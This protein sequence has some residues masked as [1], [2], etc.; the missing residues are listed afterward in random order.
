MARSH[1]AE[2]GGKTHGPFV[3][4]YRDLR[5]NQ[6][7]PEVEDR[8]ISVEAPVDGRNNPLAL[9]EHDAGDFRIARLYRRPEIARAEEREEEQR[10]EKQEIEAVALLLAQTFDLDANLP[11]IFNYDVPST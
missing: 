1:G 5:N 4:A 6:N 9:D 8:F 2:G 10:A 11:D 3:R 7:K